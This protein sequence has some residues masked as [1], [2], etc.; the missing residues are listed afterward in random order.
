VAKKPEIPQDVFFETK[1][2]KPATKSTAKPQAVKPAKVTKVQVTI[3]L[4]EQTAKDLEKAR[5]ELLSSHDIRVPKSAIAEYA[6]CRAAADIPALA[7]AL[8]DSS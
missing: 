3:Y 5:F 2:K 1:Q 8:A 7:S 4:S 6:I